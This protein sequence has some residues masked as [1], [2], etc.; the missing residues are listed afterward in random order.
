MTDNR[1]SGSVLLLTVMLMAVLTTATLGGIAVR[2]DQLASTDKISSSAVAKLAADSALARLKEKLITGSAPTEARVYNLDKNT[3]DV[4]AG[5]DTSAFKPNPLTSFGS[6]EPVKTALPRCVAVAVISP[7]VNTGSYLFDAQDQASARLANPALIFYYANIV[8]DT[9]LGTIADNQNALNQSDAEKTISELTNLGHFYNPYATST[10]QA[11]P[12]YWLIK[13]AGPEDEFLT[14]KDFDGQSS[15][16]Q[17]LDF[18]YVPYLPRFSDSGLFNAATSGTKLDRIS[19]E[20]LR[21]KF[22]E[23]IKNN[24]FRV[25]L[26]AAMSDELLYQYGLGDLFVGSNE[27]RLNWLQPGLWNDSPEIDLAGPYQS[28]NMNGSPVTWTKKTQPL[29]VP[30]GNDNQWDVTIIKGAKSFSFF[31]LNTGSSNTTFAPGATVDALLYGSL[32]GLRFNQPLTLQLYAKDSRSPL[33]LDS[34]YRNKD[35][36]K[37]YNATI[38]R[39]GPPTVSD[40]IESMPISFKLGAGDYNTPKLLDRSQHNY[41][42]VTD[43]DLAAVIAGPQF[44]TKTSS[45][46]VTLSD[47]SGND[48]KDV[49]IVIGSLPN[50]NF[51]QVIACPAV[52]DIIS[53]SKNNTAPLWTKIK[54]ITFHSNG[55]QVVS[56]Q[57]DALRQL[58]KPLRDQAT[59]TF[60]DTTDGNKTKIAFYGG[61]VASNEYDGGN[62]SEID[63]LWFYDPETGTDG[64]WQ[65]RNAGGTLPGKRAGGNLVF[66]GVN[67]RLLLFGG[68]YHEPTDSSCTED[69]QLSC[70]FNNR[71]KNRIAKRLPSDV[72]AYSLSGN[73]WSK[74]DYSFDASQKIQA[75][76]AYRLKVASTLADRSGLETWQW[77]PLGNYDGSNQ[78]SLKV[79]GTENVDVQVYQSTAGLSKGDEVFLSGVQGDGKK[80]TA[81]AKITDTNFVN[82][83]INLIVY[84]YKHNNPTVSLKELSIQVQGRQAA[85]NQCTGGKDASYYWCDLS[86]GDS[87]G[88]AVGDG[89]VLEL[90]SADKLTA[91]LSG[92]I[93]VIES[94]RVYFVADEKNP[95]I[96]DFSNN[97][98]SKVLGESPIN[99]PAPRYGSFWG[100]QPADTTVG[101]LYGGSQKN[102]NLTARFTDVWQVK[103]NAGSG[104]SSAVWSRKV[105]SSPLP[106]TSPGTLNLQVLKWPTQSMVFSATNASPALVRDKCPDQEPSCGNED[107]IWDNGKTWTLPLNKANG[108]ESLAF[109]RGAQDRFILI[110]RQNHNGDREAF[111]G[112]ISS[113]T[114][115]GENNDVNLVVNHN[116]DFPADPGFATNSNNAKITIYY[117]QRT[118]INVGRGT[119]NSAGY[120]DLTTIGDSTQIPVI[121]MTVMIWQANLGNS[122]DAHI[123]TI[124]DRSYNPSNGSYRF[125]AHD[126]PIASPLPLYS[127]SSQIAADGATIRAVTLADQQQPIPGQGAMEWFSTLSDAE[128]RWQAR[129]SNPATTIDDRPSS[130]LGAALTNVFGSSNDALYIVGGSTMG[131]YGSLWRETEAG[132]VGPSGPGNRPSWQLVKASPTAGSDLPN[133]S[134]GVLAAYRVGPLT[135]AIYFGGKQKLDPIKSDYG[136][137]VGA[138]VEGLPDLDRFSITDGT[139]TLAGSQSSVPAQPFT[140]ILEN[141]YNGP[142]SAE[143]SFQLS[144]N[145]IEP[146]GSGWGY[147]EKACAYVGQASNCDV[148]NIIRH[149]GT[150]GRIS[151]DPTSRSNFGGYSW[152]KSAAII[153]PGSAFAKDTTNANLIL[154]GPGRSLFTTNNR[155][156]QDGYYPYKADTGTPYGTLASDFGSDKSLLLAGF[157]KISGG[158][159]LL[160]TPAGIGAGLNRGAN[161]RWYSYCPKSETEDPDNGDFTCKDTA[162]RYLSFL[163]DPEDLVFLYNAAAALS[164]T[165][166]YKVVGYYGNVRRGYIVVSRSGTDL[167][168]QEIVP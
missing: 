101:Q 135:K 41:P 55:T 82:K 6:Y 111:H 97:T 59:T 14:K 60:I 153:N 151:N 42:E 103:F 18:V 148:P 9:A 51:P 86:N 129:L 160:V 19:G 25:W 63:E 43:V 158:G 52:G 100:L 119:W 70:L 2:F 93:S 28:S 113:N 88:Y 22:E 99:F 81:W 117:G 34:A 77:R 8:S 76:A 115:S 74:I 144:Q 4:L 80:F 167:R 11:D 94:G 157:A 147:T 75:G 132:K 154:S 155:W 124:Y 166:T 127:M 105:Q 17:D 7:W 137:L 140:N 98:G 36:G 29:Y 48:G 49:D 159:A 134:G 152:G 73:S 146:D 164:S 62:A 87:T 139:T 79:D 58:P 65:W 141:N 54:N 20:A 118:D 50:C 37:L 47:P 46:G 89:V 114:Y 92:Y 85:A 145:G 24:N 161:N 91:T 121:G 84:G 53:L 102:N 104:P 133:L 31:K 110:E 1:S 126:R 12:N 138:K 15:F 35:Q 116:P 156:E 83:K 131:R 71:V 3:D 21:V 143:K 122:Y 38:S 56:V 106:S 163:P 165:D 68:Y 40:G 61:A 69:K 5:N 107:K 16:Y 130:R 39:L 123:F 162:S 26:D 33:L 66:D 112:R 142:A 27:Y 95:T 90:Y 128:P 44:T 120:F 64:T 78:L 45:D 67:N 72:Y 10:N 125:W 149:L 96:A 109:D 57:A 168:I 108:L 150:L 136:R 23:T 30:T 13:M 32:E